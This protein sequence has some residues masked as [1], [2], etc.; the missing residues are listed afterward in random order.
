[1]W[2]KQKID[3]LLKM[4]NVAVKCAK[5]WTISKEIEKLELRFNIST[6][7]NLLIQKG[8]MK[9]TTFIDYN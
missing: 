2:A 8:N 1:L 5:R 3:Y 6:P 4:R 9:I 7:Y